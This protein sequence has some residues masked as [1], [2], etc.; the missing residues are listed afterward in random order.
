[1]PSYTDFIKCQT[2]PLN[3]LWSYSRL[4]KWFECN[5]NVV[6]KSHCL[7]ERVFNLENLVYFT[8]QYHCPKYYSYA[9]KFQITN[10]FTL[11]S[12]TFHC[13]FINFVSFTI[14]KYDGW[15]KYDFMSNSTVFHSYQNDETV[16]MKVCLQ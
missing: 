11:L 3:Y 16:K 6:L 12:V 9:V 7:K 4:N 1:M 2:V 13:A 8:C 5:N 10:T 15:K 14:L